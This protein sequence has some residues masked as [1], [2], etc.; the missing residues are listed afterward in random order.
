MIMVWKQHDNDSSDDNDDDDNN[1][2]NRLHNR[3][4]NA[5]RMKRARR[6]TTDNCSNTYFVKTHVH[7]SDD[8]LTM[9]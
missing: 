8:M 3:N 5:I 7:E 2:D 4:D 1:D 6:L 9:P